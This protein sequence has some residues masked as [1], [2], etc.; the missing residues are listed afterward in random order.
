[1]LSV[2]FIYVLRNIKSYLYALLFV[3]AYFEQNER[4]TCDEKAALSNE[5]R[6][7]LRRSPSKGFTSFTSR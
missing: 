1:M 5:D 4:R 6:V 7:H 3:L 2:L